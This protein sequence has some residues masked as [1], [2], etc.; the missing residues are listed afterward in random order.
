MGKKELTDSIVKVWEK[1]VDVQMH[2]NDLI[3]KNRTIVISFVTAIFGAAAYS[4]KDTTL[5]ITICSKEIHISA[6][7]ILFGIFFLS[8][9]AYLDICYYLRLLIG[10][11]KFTEEMDCEYKG[12]GLTSRISKEIKHKRARKVLHR[13]YIT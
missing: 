10:S 8:A 4:L 7:I 6:V 9:Y 5:F 3:M 13:H 11:V 1:S 2:F 12:L